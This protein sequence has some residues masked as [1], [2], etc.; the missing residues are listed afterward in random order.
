MVHF[1]NMDMNVCKAMQRMVRNDEGQIVYYMEG[2]P[3]GSHVNVR[4]FSFP[5]YFLSCES[6]QFWLD[7]Q[8]K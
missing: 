6:D 1:D 4:T 2:D 8:M 3:S 5:C 7:E